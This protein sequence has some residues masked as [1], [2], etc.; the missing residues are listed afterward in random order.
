M[1]D[2]FMI[3]H[4]STIVEAAKALNA[5][6]TTCWPRLTANE[7]EQGRLIRIVSVCWLNLHDGD[8]SS[9]PSSGT[10]PE[11][12]KELKRTAQIISALQKTSE[13]H[14]ASEMLAIIAREPSLSQLFQA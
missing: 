1:N 9:R 5:C 14:L 11:L 2:P 8:L 13:S 10:Q 7:Q 12:A 4:P 3:S 6:L